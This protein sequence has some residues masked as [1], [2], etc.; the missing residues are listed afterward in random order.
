[1]IDLNNLDV[2][3][4]DYIVY[5]QH[6]K[7]VRYAGKIEHYIRY[8]K[9]SQS[10][11]VTLNTTILGKTY[12]KTIRFSDHAYTASGYINNIVVADDR[13]LNKHERNMVRTLIKKTIRRLVYGAGVN[14]VVNYKE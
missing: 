3:I 12:S 4:K 7:E 10:I 8:S 11:Y 2:F 14:A 1:M 13:P 6:T 9:K 5:L